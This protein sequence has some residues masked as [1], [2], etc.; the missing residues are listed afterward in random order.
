MCIL[1]LCLRIYIYI[2]DILRPSYVEDIHIYVIQIV[3]RTIH[4]VRKQEHFTRNINCVRSKV[5]ILFSF[6]FPFFFL[7]FFRKFK[8]SNYHGLKTTT[9]L[10]ISYT[11]VPGFCSHFGK[12]EKK[13]NKH[14]HGVYYLRKERGWREGE[15]RILCFSCDKLSKRGSVGIK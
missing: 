1:Y 11:Q 8:K 13:E 3:K 10:E 9:R 7:F 4:L 6:P 14:G 12:T 2:Y 5:K 15:G